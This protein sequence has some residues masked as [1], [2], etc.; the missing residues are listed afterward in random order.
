M[1]GALAVLAAALALFSAT[2]ISPHIERLHLEGA[3]RGLGDAG[4]ELDAV[5]HT[6]ESI[7]KTELALLLGVLV[8]R[9]FRKGYP[10]A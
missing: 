5:H 4:Q 3:I 2:S 7:A 10:E 6:A 1:R 8:L 9:P